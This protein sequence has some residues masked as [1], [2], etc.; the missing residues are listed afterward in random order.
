M[1]QKEEAEIRAK[2]NELIS[3]NQGDGIGIKEFLK[4]VNINE[5]ANIIKFVLESGENQERLNVA[6]KKLI[7]EFS[8]ELSKRCFE[9]VGSNDFSVKT[10]S[11]TAGQEEI[12]QL[13]AAQC[14]TLCEKAKKEEA[15]MFD[16]QIDMFVELIKSSKQEK[17]GVKE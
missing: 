1:D 6:Y 17:E 2:L 7:Q 16:K 4:S 15:S 11:Y 9:C 13:V 14:I 3:S 10:A 5:N 12:S 8:M